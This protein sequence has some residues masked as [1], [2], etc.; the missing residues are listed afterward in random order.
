MPNRKNNE[1]LRMFEGNNQ[2]PNKVSTL[3]EFFENSYPALFAIDEEIISID[4]LDVVDL[5]AD[6]VVANKTADSGLRVADYPA[7]LDFEF[8]FRED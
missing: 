8:I 6:K 4:T 1:I 5:G 2:L 3:Q 7:K